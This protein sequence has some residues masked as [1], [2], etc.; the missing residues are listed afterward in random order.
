MSLLRRILRRPIRLERF[1]INNDKRQKWL[2][3]FVGAAASVPWALQT[4]LTRLGRWGQVDNE[5]FVKQYMCGALQRRV[6]IIMNCLS[7]CM[8]VW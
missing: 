4:D 3:S 7:A 8:L 2:K 5:K 1:G 6:S